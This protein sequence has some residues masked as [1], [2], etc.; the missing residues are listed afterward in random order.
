[1]QKALVT[2]VIPIHLE[3]PSELERISLD[4]ILTVLHKHPITFM[5]PTGLNTAWYE[6]YCQGKAAIS[7]ARFNWKGHEAYGELMVS[8]T[9]YKSFLAYEYMLVCHLDA[10]VFR[11]ELEEWCQRGYDYIGS[12]IYNPVWEFIDTPLRRMMGF[13]FPEYFGNGGFAL[14]KVS[15]FYGITS[16]YKWYFDAYHWVRKLRRK[17]FLDDLFITQHFPRLAANFSIPQRAVAQKF[18]AA[19]EYWE[20]DKLPFDKN[21]VDTLPFGIH[22]WIQY[23]QDYW[24]SCIRQYGYS[25]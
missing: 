3:K 23:H 7:F 8:P 24:K 22:G 20:E 17:E 9:F 18:G 2:V 4:Q 14:K 1:M 11:D 6:D 13:P 19:Y 10:F 12:V 25:I 5:A 15:A 21:K 16:K